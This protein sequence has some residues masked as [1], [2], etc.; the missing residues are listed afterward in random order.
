[1][2]IFY[3]SSLPRAGSSLIQNILA[4]NPDFHVTPTDGLLE[5]IYS[6]RSNYTS[7]PEFK[8]QDADLMKSAFL[9]FCKK[10]MEGYCEALTD[11]PFIVN[12]SRG[13][14]VHYNLLNQIQPNPKIICMVRDARDIFASLE[15]KFRDNQHLADN[16]VDWSIMKGTN[17]PKRIDIWSQGVPVGMAFER[18]KQIID[19][20]I[21]KNICF[22]RYEDLLNHPDRELSRIYKYF[23][24]ENFK[25]DFENI[26]QI[27]VEDDDVY[28]IY[29]DHKIQTSLQPLKHSYPKTFT[30]EVNRWIFDNY[31]WFNDY[32]SYRY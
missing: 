24:I 18:L 27:T 8:A 28:G 19:E 16:M 26:K 13:W 12:K 25:H 2:K 6:A 20:G 11:K 30:N 32:F 10:G 31:K 23:E 14:G 5:L 21:D 4:Q 9:N 29:G 15:K 7:S 17:T 1:M 3:N 22:V